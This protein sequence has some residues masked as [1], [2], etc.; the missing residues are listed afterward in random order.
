MGV[1]LNRMGEVA[2]YDDPGLP[3]LIQPSNVSRYEDGSVFILDRRAYPFEVRYEH[4]RS[5]EETARAIESMVTQSGGPGLAAAHGMIQAARA[6]QNDPDP[7][8]RL[9]DA[10]DRLRSTRPTHNQIRRAVDHLLAEAARA[11]QSGIALEAAMIESVDY[12]A[13]ARYDRYQT[14]GEFGASLL[15]DGDTL[16]THCWGEG[17]I[18][19]TVLN[20]VKQGKAIEAIVTETRP[21]LQGARLTADAMLDMGIPT[22]VITDGMHAGVLADRVSTFMTG[23]DLITMSGH[24]VNK[25][26]T[27]PIA[28]MAHHYGVPYY[29]FGLGPDPKAETPDDVVIENRDPDETLYCLGQRTATPRARGHYPAFDI[30]PPE[31]VTGIVTNRGVSAPNDLT[32]FVDADPVF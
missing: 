9:R 5:Y 3:F 30:T 17:G 24:V 19:F 1:G 26:G 25:I 20:A 18:V 8:R 32:A 22:T 28:M 6:A 10:G 4:C 2:P 21:Y 13:R 27:F 23:A 15:E 31:Y 12:L 11:V 29:A 16:L 7:M 14:T